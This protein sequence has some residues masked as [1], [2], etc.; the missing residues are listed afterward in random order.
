MNLSAVVIDRSFFD[1]K[2]EYRDIIKN[3]Y[4]F[5]T[6]ITREEMHMSD[7]EV[8]LIHGTK[9]RNLQGKSERVG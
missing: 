7:I 6:S 3:I 9:I 5:I 2:T 1:N 8:H 4:N